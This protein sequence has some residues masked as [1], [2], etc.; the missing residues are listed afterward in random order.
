MSSS[1]TV[2]PGGAMRGASRATSNGTSRAASQSASSKPVRLAI[3]AV[4]FRR[5]RVV[6]S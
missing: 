2:R 1:A 6:P 4:G 3:A 5:S